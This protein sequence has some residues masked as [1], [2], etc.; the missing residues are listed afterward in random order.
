[1]LYRPS[2]IR[3]NLSD[4]SKKIMGNKWTE[5]KRKQVEDQLKMQEYFSTDLHKTPLDIRDLL[6]GGPLQEYVTSPMD[7]PG[8]LII[9]DQGRK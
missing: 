2:L 8:T 7:F 9:T 3:W 5:G 4:R 1:M 6:L